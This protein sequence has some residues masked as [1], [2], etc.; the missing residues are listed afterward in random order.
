MIQLI[1]GTKGRGK[2]KILLEK[3]NTAI[4]DAKGNIAYL[5]KSNKHMHELK[6]KIRLINVKSYLVDNSEEFLG[7]I[8]GIISQDHDLEAIYIDSFLKIS[9][10]ECKDSEH[11]IPMFDKLAKISD[12]YKVE[13]IISISC[14]EDELPDT[15]KKYVAVSL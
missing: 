3:V 15:L 4:N 9:H 2:T 7:F 5:D 14:S 6:R 10:L 12:M 1:T 13:F 11:L 8:C